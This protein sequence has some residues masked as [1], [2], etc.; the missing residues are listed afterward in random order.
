[1]HDD[2]ENDIS[3]DEILKCLKDN[4]SRGYDGIINDFLKTSS[5]KL[6]VSVTILLSSFS[7]FDL[8]YLV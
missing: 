8:F 5:P 1:M 6:L 3:A 4:K 7:V 2:V